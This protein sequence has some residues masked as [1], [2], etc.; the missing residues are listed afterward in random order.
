MKAHLPLDNKTKASIEEYCRWY[1]QE[2]NQQA[3]GIFI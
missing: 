2:H 1:E 3:M